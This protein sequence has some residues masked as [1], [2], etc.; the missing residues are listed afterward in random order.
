MNQ[1]RKRKLKCWLRILTPS[2]KNHLWK[3]R[4]TFGARILIQTLNQSGVSVDGT[5]SVSEICFD[6]A[7]GPVG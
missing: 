4:L 6:K 7:A 3:E 5:A 2:Q 1:M